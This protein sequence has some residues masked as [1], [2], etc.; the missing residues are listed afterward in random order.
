M[1]LTKTKTPRS[2]VRI[3]ARVADEIVA[4]ACERPEPQVSVGTCDTYIHMQQHM[5]WADVMDQKL[6]V[7]GSPSMLGSQRSCN[8]AFCI[9]KRQIHP[10]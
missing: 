7:G 6:A 9:S 3:G 8:L 5:V 1:R 4:T 2:L 10:S